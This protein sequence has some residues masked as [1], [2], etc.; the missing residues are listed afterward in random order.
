MADITRELR[1]KWEHRNEQRVKK[2]NIKSK[3]NN[4]LARYIPSTREVL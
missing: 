2:K 1:I 3:G 4:K